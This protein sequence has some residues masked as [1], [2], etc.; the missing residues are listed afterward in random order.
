MSLRPSDLGEAVIGGA[1]EILAFAFEQASGLIDPI[2]ID[3]DG[4]G[5]TT[6]DVSTSQVNFDLDNNGIAETT[7]W[8][9]PEDGFIAHDANG[10]GV[11]NDRSEL[12]DTFSKLSEFDINGDGVLDA[13]DVDTPPEGE[14]A[15]PGFNDLRIW[16]DADK[17]GVTE[18]LP[19]GFQA[20][21]AVKS[22]ALECRHI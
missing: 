13:N 4:D 7:G 10:D 19:F 22:E 8:I 17:D 16:V 12:F 3:L 21:L 9:E 15:Q 1:I 20:S 6:V 2:A 11:I 18:G 5:I 14:A